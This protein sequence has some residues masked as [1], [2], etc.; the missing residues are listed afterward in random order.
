MTSNTNNR[1]LVSINFHFVDFLVV[2]FP[3]LVVIIES[4]VPSLKFL[5]IS[6][7]WP[8]VYLHINSQN[9]NMVMLALCSITFYSQTVKSITHTPKLKY[10]IKNT[11]AL[12][13]CDT[14]P[15]HKLHPFTAKQRSRC[16][17]LDFNLYSVAKIEET[18][19]ILHSPMCTNKFKHYYFLTSKS[20][21]P[22]G[23]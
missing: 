20:N 5:H 11:W 13:E 23:N 15:K 16:F 8:T 18:F 1:G 12:W 3:L 19:K 6:C 14:H 21:T 17:S 2:T 4:I 7:L 9:T 10:K 22:G